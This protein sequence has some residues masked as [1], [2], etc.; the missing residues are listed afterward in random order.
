MFK[1]LKE[2]NNIMQ[3]KWE[4]YKKKQMKFLEMKTRIS[5]M[6]MTLG[7]IKNRLGTAKER[8]HELEDTAIET[9]Q[10]KLK[11]WGKNVNRAS[12]T[13]DTVSRE[14]KVYI[15]ENSGE[16]KEVKRERRQIFEDIMWKNISRFDENYKQ[17]GLQA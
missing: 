3:K 4:I 7:R 1:N 16:K 17:T 13:Y 6:K 12:V 5:I 11:H 14:S 15:T 8:I 9:Q 2:K 10:S